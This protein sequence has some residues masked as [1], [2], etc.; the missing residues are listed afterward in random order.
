MRAGSGPSA[1]ATGSGVP[2]LRSIRLP[3]AARAASA[4]GFVF[5]LAFASSVRRASPSAASAF[6]LARLG[7][8]RFRP[9]RSRFPARPSGWAALPLRGCSGRSSATCRGRPALLPPGYG[10]TTTGSGHRFGVP[11]SGTATAS[12]RLPRSV[13]HRLLAPGGFGSRR[14]R[15]A[16]SASRPQGCGP[17]HAMSAH[18]VR[19]LAQLFRFVLRPAPYTWPATRRAARRN[20]PAP[21]RR[22]R[23]AAI[24][25]PLPAPP[26]G[27]P[28]RATA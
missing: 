15:P 19:R 22:L 18:P 26:R 3:P 28:P 10:A 17:Y 2:F 7:T 16:F 6:G 11:A 21:G 12:G 24:P 27:Y 8:L 4:L 14:R 1:S 13:G 9:R 25:L 5:A 20:R 23:A